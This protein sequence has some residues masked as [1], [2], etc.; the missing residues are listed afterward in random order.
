[1]EGDKLV[2]CFQLHPSIHSG[3]SQVAVLCNNDNSIKQLLIP[4]IEN[5]WKEKLFFFKTFC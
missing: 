4:E 5:K 2:S 3:I 1:M